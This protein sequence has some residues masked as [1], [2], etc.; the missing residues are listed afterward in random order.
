MLARVIAISVAVALPA[1][2][3]SLRP[4]SAYDF[5]YPGPMNVQHLSTD[6]VN[7]ECEALLGGTLK[8]VVRGCARVI[9][10]TCTIILA[11]Y[12]KV[13][14]KRLLFRHEQAHC[15]GWVHN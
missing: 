2:A 10:G 14:D 11:K 7:D 8:P 9:E 13:S 5:P 12:A 3:S 6:N 1:Q 15:N 4:P